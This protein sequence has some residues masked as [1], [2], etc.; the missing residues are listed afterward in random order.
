MKSR[1]WNDFKTFDYKLGTAGCDNRFTG[2]MFGMRFL[3]SNPC[4]TIQTVHLHKTEIRNYNPRDIQPAKLYLYIHP[5]AI[6]EMVNAKEGPVKAFSL[7]PRLGS[8][9]VKTVVPKKGLTFCTMLARE[10]RFKWSA[11]VANVWSAKPVTVYRWSKA[12]V[13]SPGIVFDYKNL[14]T[15]TDSDTFFQKIGRNLEISFLKPVE[16]TDRMLAVPCATV[17]QMTHPDLY[18]LYYLSYAIQ[19]LSQIEGI[20]SFF[21]HEPCISTLEAFQVK[22][23]YAGQVPLIAWN[24]GSVVYAKEACGFLP[25]N[26]ELSPN[27]IEAL[28]SH[29]S[30]YQERTGNRCVVLTDE[31]LTPEFC[32]TVLS[33]LL[34]SYEIV[35]LPRTV[36]GTQA[37]K[38]LA[39]TSLCLLYNLPKQEDQWAKLWALPKGCRVLEFQNELKVEG[40]F[41][42]LAS[43]AGFDTTLIPLHKGPI[44]DLQGQVVEQIKACAIPVKKPTTPQE[45]TKPENVI[46]LS[47]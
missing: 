1:S 18:C 3:I 43:M 20:A 5:C 15:G 41:Q 22:S 38:V 9:I 30:G 39:G 40:G 27:E 46:L 31:I 34:S 25:S 28:R 12:F 35:C 37:Y 8:V 29:W 24:P 4:H 2:D 10:N 19:V 17:Q 21:I 47:V 6:I 44:E 14:Y 26:T 45:T 11:E 36:F 42:H 33:P 13:T 32:T 7:S 16:R 23:G